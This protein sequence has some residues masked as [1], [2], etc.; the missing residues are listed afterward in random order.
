MPFY[1]DLRPQSDYDKRDYALVFPDMQVSEK[2]RTITNLLR[3]KAGL[4]ENIPARKTNDNLLIAS[5]N[6]KEFGHTLQRLNE[7]YFYIAEIISRFDLVAVQ[8]VKSTLKDLDIVMRILGSDWDYLVN[9]ITDGS[10]G[11]SERSAYLFNKKRL[12]LSGLA[13]ELVLW[14]EITTGSAI[15]QLKR[16][17]YITGFKSAWKSF[18]MLNMHLHPGDDNDDLAYRNEEVRLLLVALEHKMDRLWSRNLILAGDFNLYQGDDNETIQLFHDA[19][20]SEIDGLIGLDT[21]ASQTQAYD[22]LFVH[23]NR[24]FQVA[25]N[26][27]GQEIGN[28]FNPFDYVYKQEEHSQY[29]QQM[30]DDYGG[31]KDLNTDAVALEKYFMRYWRR[32]QISDHFPIWFELSTDS[33]TEFLGK[34]FAQLGVA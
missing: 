13:G 32:N 4:D 17:P 20:F 30:V 22:R 9:D 14:P 15:K 6:I 8:E 10:S 1:N 12:N 5:W 29:Q 28:V 2:R 21:N 23:K 27:Q 33:S 7:A 3:L 19:G 34:K 31:A 16:T 26:A 25:T 11:N 24:Y 18:V